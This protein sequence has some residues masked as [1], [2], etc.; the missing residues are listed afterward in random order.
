MAV[1]VA[2]ALGVPGLGADYYAATTGADT[3]AGTFAS[4]FRTIQKAVDEVGPGD[5]VLIRGGTYR[6]TVVIR[7]S[8]TESNNVEILS[9]A[10]ETPV[11]KGSD[12]IT[13]WTHHSNFIW[14][15]ENWTTGCQQVFADD[16]LLQQ[17]GYPNAFFVTNANQ[18]AAIG[19]D[20][21]DMIPGSFFCDTNQ[22]VLYV[23]LPD[24]SDPSG[25]IIE[26]SVRHALLVVKTGHRYIYIDGIR[27]QHT[28]SLSFSNFAGS[29]V[30][31]G[32]NCEIVN[33]R[34]ELCD[35]AGVTLRSN[36][37]ITDSD[38]SRNG[39]LGITWGESSNVVV[40]GCTVMSNNVSH[41]QHSWHAG[42]MKI[43]YNL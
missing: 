22:N 15:V 3:N 19:S 43:I 30:G 1:G 12:I 28:S 4:P 26:A 13:G 5:R 8:G 41:F 7:V 24:S 6:E 32:E 14:K 36:S 33:C 42:G 35:F 10:N 31:L 40:S 20:A 37:R 21:S 25:H 11:V 23:W 27:F 17:I 18:Y 39:N 16:I 29:G 38:V 9:Y 34:I 2:M